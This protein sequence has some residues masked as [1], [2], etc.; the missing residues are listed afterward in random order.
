M[1][2]PLSLGDLILIGA[3]ADRPA[4]AV[5]GRIYLATDGTVPISRDNGTTWEAPVASSASTED[6]QDIV[7]AMITAGTNM[8]V[9]YNDPAGSLTLDAT[10]PSLSTEAVQDIA[11]AMFVSGGGVSVSYNDGAGTLTFAFAYG[12]GS[13]FETGVQSV[14]VSFFGDRLLPAGGAT[15]SLLMKSSG[16]D[17]DVGWNDLPADWLVPV[18]GTTD[19]VLKKAS[20]DDRDVT[21]A[22]DEAGLGGLDDLTNVALDDP[23][24]GDVLIKGPTDWTN[25]PLSDLV[26]VDLDDLADVT[27]PSPTNGQVLTWDTDH[28]EAAD[29][30]GGGDTPEPSP[31]NYDQFGVARFPTKASKVENVGVAASATEDLITLTGAGVVT[32]LTLVTGVFGGDDAN[33]TDMVFR[34]FVDGEVDPAIEFDLGVLG[35]RFL[36]EHVTQQTQHLGIQAAPTGDSALD[37]PSF[38]VTLRFPIP[39]GDGIKFQ[40]HNPTADDTLAF[41]NVFY[42]TAVTQNRRLR[43]AGLTW[44]DKVRREVGDGDYDLL[45]LASGAGTVVWHSMAVQGVTG[46]AYLESNIVARVDGEFAPSLQTSGTEDWFCDSF[47]WA[48]GPRSTPW[49]YLGT[50]DLDT[51]YT[52]ATALDILALFGGLTFTD[53]IRLTWELGG[54]FSDVDVSYLV[55]YYDGEDEATIGGASTPTPSDEDFAIMFTQEGNVALLVDGRIAT[56]R[57]A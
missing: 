33:C 18:G 9:T 42:T 6:I 23:Q 1:A 3:F 11:G 17:Y 44:A 14:V 31:L 20:N 2:S 24:V 45:D 32:A 40:F 41:L 26:P 53:G 16:D 13:A 5:I 51:N 30:M 22:D 12:S 48:T 19:Q 37:L 56:R 55:L 43:S 4:A 34:I 25:A 46:P 38:Q 7:A 29:P 28:W 27:A 49:A 35:S 39:F 50:I 36:T 54:G 47:Y 10:V 57:L 8:A 21:W 52:V 15:N